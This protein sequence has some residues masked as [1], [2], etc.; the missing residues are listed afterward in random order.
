MQRCDLSF[1]NKHIR[2]GLVRFTLCWVKKF[3]IVSLLVSEHFTKICNDFSSCLSH[4]CSDAAEAAA[5][6]LLTF[7]LCYSVSVDPMLDPDTDFL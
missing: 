3:V 2:T 7:C 6:A 5:V 4:K 1:R